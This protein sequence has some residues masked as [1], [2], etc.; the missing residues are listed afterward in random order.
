M[1]RIT[2]TNLPGLSDYSSS[3]SR[4]SENYRSAIGSTYR[5]FQMKV[6]GEQ[7]EA[8]SA[9]LAK[10]NQVQATVFEA[11]PTVLD[12]YAQALSRYEDQMSGF[13]FQTKA[14]T[15]D[16]GASSVS[17][18][19]TGEQIDHIQEVKSK[20][21]SAL[22]QASEAL[23]MSDFSLT[24][25]VSSIE[26]NLMEAGRRRTELDQKMQV[27]Y[28]SFMRDLDVVSQN[29]EALKGSLA[30]AQ[31]VIQIPAASIATAIKNGSLAPGEVISYLDAVQTK[32]DATVL[33]A[34]LS[35]KVEDLKEVASLNPHSISDEGYKILAK[36]M[37]TWIN[38]SDK[39][40]MKSMNVLINELGKKTV[41]DN[42]VFFDKLSVATT[43]IAYANE[44]ALLTVIYT[45]EFKDYQNL[46]DP[47]TKRELE[48]NKFMGLIMGLQELKYGQTKIET[49]QWNN[50]LNGFENVVQFHD[51]SGSFSYDENG[52]LVL[53]MTHVNNSPELDNLFSNKV[54]DTKYVELSTNLTSFIL[55][56]S[57][58]EY[59]RLDY[60]KKEL[61]QKAITDTLLSIGEKAGDFLLPG[62]ST[63]FSILSST[64]SSDLNSV[65][66]TLTDEMKD[67]GE[68]DARSRAINSVANASIKVS[69]IFSGLADAA[70][71]YEKLTIAQQNEFLSIKA[72]FLGSGGYTISENSGKAVQQQPGTF[73]YR[74]SLRAQELDQHGVTS[75]ITDS[76]NNVNFTVADYEKVLSEKVANG[77]FDPAVAAYLLGEDNSGLS[78]NTMTFEQL[79]EFSNG[80]DLFAEL[81]NTKQQN[82]EFEKYIS[83]LYNES[84]DFKQ[85][86]NR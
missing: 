40:G 3:I 2:I 28:D 20:L 37:S 42:A 86:G 48:L 4:F 85:G 59:N 44:V 70:Y 22:D 83:N 61:V 19:L 7:A 49:P 38:S 21:Q 10:L 8:I 36:E 78:F 16:A 34:V 63:A 47:F 82:N 60:A 73:D 43:D 45:D 56:G 81:D 79:Q 31:S 14:W 9:F 32:E 27:A 69:Q 76:S 77:E 58:A 67:L 17:G 62:S 71:E 18:K 72:E 68:E 12:S 54:T 51:V 5:S 24:G 50:N 29:F 25:K 41:E 75:F 74:V 23:D 57:F 66:S 64:I 35:R 13:G 65:V 80:V 53:S 6:D 11:Y 33:K 39:V 46:I 55:D 52:R 26:T 84:S 15:D 30:N 1:A